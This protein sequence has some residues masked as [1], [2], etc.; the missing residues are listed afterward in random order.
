VRGAGRALKREG[1]SLPRPHDFQLWNELKTRGH[2]VMPHG[3]L[4]VN[5]AEL[6]LAEAKRLIEACL[7]MFRSK[8]AGFEASTA[9]FAFPYNRSTPEL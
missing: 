6:P 2:Y 5:N 8:L 4:H 9:S 7:E 3:Y 1:P